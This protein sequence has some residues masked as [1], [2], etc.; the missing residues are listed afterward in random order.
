[1]RVLDLIIKKRDGGILTTEEIGHLIAEFNKNNVPDYQM[2]AF[3]MAIYF[4]GL[5][6]RETTAFTA[7]LAESGKKIDFSSLGLAVVD[8]HSSGV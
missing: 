4:Q 8:K 6:A 5:N 1:M 3:L 2:A 7:A